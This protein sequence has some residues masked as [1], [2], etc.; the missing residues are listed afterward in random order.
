MIIPT[1]FLITTSPSKSTIQFCK[2]NFVPPFYVLSH[3]QYSVYY[4]V[5]SVIFW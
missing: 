3:T 5:V 1:F 4:T 2:H